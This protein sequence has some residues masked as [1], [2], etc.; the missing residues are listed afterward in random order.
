MSLHS[1]MLVYFRSPRLL[2]PPPPT[3]TCH[4]KLDEFDKTFW[5]K[6]NLNL[7][8]LN[9]VYETSD[10][11]TIKLEIASK[12]RFYQILLISFGKE[13]LKQEQIKWMEMV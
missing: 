2:P 12:F 4:I 5:H 1:A 10:T 11:T 13:T 8:P 9:Y 6:W 3:P 7:A